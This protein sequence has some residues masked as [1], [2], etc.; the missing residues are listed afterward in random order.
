MPTQTALSPTGAPRAS[1]FS[2]PVYSLLYRS[3]MKIRT[4]VIRRWYDHMSRIDRDADM[5][6][7][8]YGWAR[9]DD[10]RKPVHLEEKDETNR[11][12]IQLY[13]EVAGSVDLRGKDVLEVGSGRGGGAS[14]MSRYLKP[15]SMTGLELSPK[16]VEFCESFYSIPGL[17][18][19]EGNA[20]RLDFGPET[21]D[22]VVN[23]ESSHCYGSL[24]GFLRNV[25]RVLRPEGHFLYSDY[26]PVDRLDA[27]RSRI[28]ETGFC[29]I[30]E[31]DIS[32][33][34][35]RALELDDE[36]KRK[37]IRRKVPRFL[38]GFFHEFAG[39]QGTRSY[40]SA[41]RRGEKTYFRFVLRK[42]S[43]GR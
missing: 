4:P 3:L 40:N 10:L 33:N 36:R 41:L 35:L 30:E 17:S 43:Q 2:S 38:R 29:I 14:F 20:E 42:G 18:F 28:T 13:Y 9:T 22:A 11:Y 6:L 27:L 24:E 26:C 7:M 23:I 8:N 25:Y 31:A 32:G 12:C 16:A 34:I 37:L 39:L 5:T 21:F 19:V 1:R 15:G